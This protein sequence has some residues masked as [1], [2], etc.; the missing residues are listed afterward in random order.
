M[1]WTVFTSGPY[2]EMLSELM[3]PYPTGDSSS[4][5][6]KPGMPSDG[7]APTF[8]YAVPLGDGAVALIHLDDLGRYARW[9]FDNPSRSTGMDLEI[10]TE[11]VHFADLAKAF[12]EF[13]G[14]RAVYKPI[15]QDEYF[16]GPN[17]RGDPEVKVGHSVDPGDD[18]L[19]SYRQNFGAFWNVWKASGGNQGLVRRDY[20]LL[21]EILPDRVKSVGEWMR[22]TGYTGEAKRLLKDVADSKMRGSRNKQTRN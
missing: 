5:F 4:H 7:S 21:D 12:T 3:Q 13:T 14:R 10:A 20:K 22:K 17:W 8:V 19:Q 9:I 11:H 2:M 1:A 15:S 16:A 6:P 18:T